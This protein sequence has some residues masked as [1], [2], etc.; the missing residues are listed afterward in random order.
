MKLFLRMKNSSFLFLLHGLRYLTF[1][2]LTLF[3]NSYLIA[4]T[5]SDFRCVF[6]NV[7]NF[8]DTRNDSL[9]LDDSFTPTGDLHWT[10]SR[11]RKKRNHIYQ[12]IVAMSTVE[13]SILQPPAIIAMAEVENDMVLR[14]LCRATPLRRYGYSFVHFDSPDRR[15]IDNALLYRPDRVRVLSAYPVSVSDS[16]FRSRDILV[17]EA[18]LSSGDSVYLFVNHFPSKLGGQDAIENRRRVALRL[19]GL[20]DSVVAHCPN[21]AVIVMG[22]FN[23]VPTEAELQ[24]LTSPQDDGKFVNLMARMPRGSGSYKY[25]GN[26]DYLDQI[27]VVGSVLNG[28]NSI[29]IKGGGAHVFEAEFLTVDDDKFL[30]A[31][32]FRT[33]LGPRYQGGFSDHLPVYVDLKHQ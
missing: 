18:E 3:V 17:V 4:Q 7:E 33:Y 26:W 31:K 9:T 21:H 10:D 24:L 16:L 29:Q 20:M 11:Y 2:I 19:R 14:D 5:T 12:T 8:F 28:V 25:Q 32:P 6:W 30:G 13:N 1:L 23:A 22:D 27:I 15:G